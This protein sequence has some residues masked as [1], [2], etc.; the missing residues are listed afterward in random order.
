MSWYFFTMTGKAKWERRLAEQR[1]SVL[2]AERPEFA[3]ILDV[4]HPCDGDELPESLFY[5]GPLYFDWDGEGDLQD[6]LDDVKRFM[7]QLES[8]DFDLNQASWWLSGK[9]GVHCTIPMECVLDRKLCKNGLKDLFRIYG[10]FA[11]ENSTTYM[12]MRVYS[13]RRGRMWRTTYRPRLV[14]GRA[15]HKVAITPDHLRRLDAEGYWA[16]CSEPRPEITPAEPVLNQHM[17]TELMV[18]MSRYAEDQKTRSKTRANKDIF[19]S[20]EGETPPTVAAAFNGQSI[21]MNSTLNNIGMQFATA[22]IALGMNSADDTDKFLAACEGFIQA[23]I[24]QRGVAHSTRAEITRRLSQSFHYCL[25]DSSY[26]YVPEMFASILTEDAEQNLDLRGIK[27]GAAPEKIEDL[28][29]KLQNGLV[30]DE[31]AVYKSTKDG[32]EPVV[33]YSWKPG[34]LKIVRDPTDGRI[35][36]LSVIAVVEGVEQPRKVLPISVLNTPKE[37]SEYVVGYNATSLITTAAQIAA[38]RRALKNFVGGEADVEE[39]MTSKMEGLHFTP[40][41]D[42]EDGKYQGAMFWVEPSITTRSMVHYD[43]AVPAPDYLDTNNPSGQFGVDLSSAY[44]VDDYKTQTREVVKNLLELNGDHYSLAIML[45]WF[46]ACPLKHVLYELKRIKNFPVLQI[47]GQSGCGKTTTANL[48]LHLF[49]WKRD[50]RINMAGRNLTAFALSSLSTASASVP[51]VVDE[52]KPQNITTQ[53]LA[54]F[55]SFIQTIYTIG[56]E[57]R[58]GGGDGSI[59]ASYKTV[60]KEPMMAPVCFL[61]EALEA[62]QASI[63]ER[64]VV[65]AFHKAAVF[66]RD[67]HARFLGRHERNIGMLG[68]AIVQHLLNYDLHR[69]VAMHDKA[70]EDSSEFLAGGNNYRVIEN[71]AIMLVGFDF[72]REVIE[73]HFPGE[74]TDKLEALRHSLTVPDRWLTKVSSEVV[75]LLGMLATASYVEAESRDACRLGYHYTFES[76]E[77]IEGRVDYLVLH[78]ERCFYLYRERMKALA[79]TPAFG[80]LEELKF[81]LTNSVMAVDTLFYPDLDGG[82]CVK[83]NPTV[84]NTEGVQTFKT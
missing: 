58:R 32:F 59:T 39:V 75:R 15:T 77:S 35:T 63:L 26:A 20:W 70:V 51:L 83:L 40:T 82:E 7:T 47:V 17:Y 8:W 43:E 62:S 38:M 42:P 52:L 31:V 9:K 3:T 61:A 67:V 76:G 10:R 79:M 69:L 54:D 73:K 30:V 80:S 50:L 22:A 49:T 13:G 65:A 25:S 19:K 18:C 6:L 64:S 1:A 68:W 23:R 46:T 34:S 84:L 14:D 72:L 81:A 45:A 66:G 4:N 53:W 33:D 29:A 71:A 28:K 56:S 37:F 55:R 16:W 5:R 36:H 78:L 74:F 60:S 48:L 11:W 41:L 21:D 12:D 44:P 27:P 2:E 24:G 57:A